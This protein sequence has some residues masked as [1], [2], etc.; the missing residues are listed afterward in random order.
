MRFA[1]E[2]SKPNAF[3][4]PSIEKLSIPLFLKN[5]IAKMSSWC[6]KGLNLNPEIVE[7]GFPPA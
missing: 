4:R 2:G 5:K 3:L 7:L 1:G 6:K